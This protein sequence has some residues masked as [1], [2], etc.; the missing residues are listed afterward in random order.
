MVD[1]RVDKNWLTGVQTGIVLMD[2]RQ[3]LLSPLAPPWAYTCTA[4]PLCI[5]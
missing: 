1:I 3:N 5:R 4:G 2:T